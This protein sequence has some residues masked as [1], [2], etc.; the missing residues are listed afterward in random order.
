[1]PG[2]CFLH[3]SEDELVQRLSAANRFSTDTNED[4]EDEF[5]RN[6]NIEAERLLEHV[7]GGNKGVV[8]DPGISSDPAKQ[9]KE[10]GTQKEGEEHKFY[11]N[12]YFDSSDEDEGSTFYY[13]S[14]IIIMHLILFVSSFSIM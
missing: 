10:E 13:T 3:S 9:Q 6:M 7:I 1:M 14:I 4:I 8:K 5:E 11:D 2:N 12:V